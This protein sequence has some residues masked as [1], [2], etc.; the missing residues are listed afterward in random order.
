MEKISQEKIMQGDI[1]LVPL[2]FSDSAEC[3][4]RP[5]LI[6]SNDIFNKQSIDYICV[7]ITSIIKS[8][9]YSV[10]ITNKEL[11]SGSILSESRIR[12]DKLLTVAKTKVIRRV[13]TINMKTWSAVKKEILTLF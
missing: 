7:P 9:P 2:P 5:A 13:G 8:V 12:T 10:T 4:V 6:V 1:V 11:S 3:K